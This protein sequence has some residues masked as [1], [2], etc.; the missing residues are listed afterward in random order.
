MSRKTRYYIR[1]P[2]WIFDPKKA[3]RIVLERKRSKTLADRTVRAVAKRL[4]VTEATL[5]NHITAIRH[6]AAG[7]GEVDVEAE[8]QAAALW[9][10]AW[11]AHGLTEAEIKQVRTEMRRAGRA[12]ITPAQA[13]SAVQSMAA[14]VKRM[15]ARK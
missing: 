9:L 8:R 10:E 13:A 7:R 3:E 5:R 11:N 15:G 14:M 4:G 2:R 1:L 6:I 12:R